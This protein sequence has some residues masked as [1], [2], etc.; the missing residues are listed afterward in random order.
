[1][2]RAALV[3][4]LAATLLVAACSDDGEDQP[5][6]NTFSAQMTGTYTAVLGGDAEFGVTLDDAAKASGFALI[7]GGGTAA[8]RIV[9]FAYTAPKPRAGTYEIVAPDSPAGS[10]TVFS[11]ALTYDAGSGLETFQIRGG[12]ITLDRANHNRTAG[13]FDFRAERTSPADGAQIFISGTFDAAQ[14][15]QVFP[16][17]QPPAP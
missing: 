8:A 7:L 4:A 3:T 5:G 2:L 1:M 14:I 10:D 11:G 13:T 12:T 16:Q 6:S 9:L 15:P 17:E